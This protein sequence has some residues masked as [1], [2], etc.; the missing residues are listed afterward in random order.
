MN[1]GKWA[2]VMG[3]GYNSTSE[4]PVLLSQYLDGDRALVKMAAAAAG[5]AN[6]VS[7][8]LSAP[9]LVDIDGNGTLEKVTIDADTLGPKAKRTYSAAEFFFEGHWDKLFL[10]GSY[11]WARSTGNTEGGIKSDIGQADTGTT[12]DFDYR[13]L[14]LGAD[15]PLPNDRKHTLKVFGNYDLN[16]QWSIGGN[17]LVQSGR[18]IN[19]FGVY[20]NDPLHYGNSYFSCS[21][22]PGT[23][24]DGDG[25][26][27]LSKD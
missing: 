9:R 26:L 22:T 19:C 20:G 24:A 21:N 23:D 14:M 27:G 7:N 15:G 8:G 17:L 10:Q 13:E 12:Q 6:A 4:R 25:V 1:N 16:E 11:T 2:V 5:T 18:P 3:N